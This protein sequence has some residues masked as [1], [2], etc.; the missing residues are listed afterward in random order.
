MEDKRIY[1]LVNKWKK[2]LKLTRYEISVWIVSPKHKKLEGA[3]YALITLPED[4]D[5]VIIYLNKKNIDNE[6]ESTIF[7]ELF[8]LLIW[9]HLSRPLKA[10]IEGA[11][12][13]AEHT[14]L[15]VMEKALF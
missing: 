1:E 7:H 13:D 4:D 15:N 8:H 14:I 12:D 2:K 11:I 3:N 9:E 5:K 10:V 6:L